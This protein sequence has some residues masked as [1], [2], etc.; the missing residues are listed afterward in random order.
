MDPRLRGDDGER[1]ARYPFTGMD[2]YLQIASL[3]V[4]ALVIIAL[5]PASACCRACSGSAAVF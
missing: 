1:D 5:W 4:N 2:L 3:S